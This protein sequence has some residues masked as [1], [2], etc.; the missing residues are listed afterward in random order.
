MEFEN[1]GRAK[2]AAEAERKSLSQHG[3][4]AAMLTIISEGYHYKAAMAGNVAIDTLAISTMG[5]AATIGWYCLGE[6]SP[7]SRLPSLYKSAL[8]A[9]A[10]V[11]TAIFFVCGSQDFST[12]DM[13]HMTSPTRPEV[14]AAIGEHENMKPRY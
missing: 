3:S 8:I 7:L 10:G 2:A 9:A 5:M 6:Q 4:M 1:L 14:S 12:P 13:H 11:G